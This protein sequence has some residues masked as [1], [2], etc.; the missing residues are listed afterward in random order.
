[1]ALSWSAALAKFVNTWAHVALSTMNNLRS[2]PHLYEINTWAWLEELSERAGR[3]V[4]LAEV[5]DVEWNRLAGLGFDLIWLMGVWERSPES[6]REFRGDAASF[7]TFKKAMPGATMQDVVGSA[8]SILRYQPDPYIGDWASLDATRDKLHARG[9]RLILDFVPNHVALDHPWGLEQPE[10]FIQGTAED[11]AR[12]PSA[13]YRAET[14]SGTRYIAR[15]KDPYFPPWCDVAQLNYFK[16]AMRAALLAELGTMAKH[17]DGFRC[18]MAMLVLNDIFAKTWSSLLAGAVPPVA[19]FWREVRGAL[20]DKILLAE[21]YWGTEGRLF[22][23]GFDFAYDKTLYDA[24]RGGD[25]SAVRADISS[26][27]DYQSHLARFLENH[28]EARSAAVFIGEKLTAAATLVAT[29]PGLRFYHQGQL[30]GRRIQLP[31]ALSHAASEQPDPAIEAL[32]R[33]LLQISN[34]Q[35]FHAGAYRRLDAGDLGDGTAANLIVYDWQT[36]NCWKLVVVNL[37]NEASQ[38]RIQVGDRIAPGRRYRFNDQLNQT[39]YLRDGDEL[40]G[41]GL[42]VRLE[43]FHAHLFEIAPAA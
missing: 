18:D 36:E 10:Y 35:V 41:A 34:E 23:L 22:E 11:F 4:T 39:V 2:Q 3:H 32:Y 33:Q 9:L 24:I 6:R 13:Y 37:G 14:Y 42:Y 5:P 20:P 43:A 25:A 30:E 28:D 27:L 21:A 12:D 17:C 1:M 7:A 31:V 15:A 38:A 40:R 29:L 19:E 16:S 8:Y 26:D